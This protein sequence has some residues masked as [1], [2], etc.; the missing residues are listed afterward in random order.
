MNC[1][2]AACQIFIE[3]KELRNCMSDISAIA[4]SNQ[5]ISY[6]RTTEAH[7]KNASAPATGFESATP[8]HRPCRSLIIRL[9]ASLS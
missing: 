8:T 9:A 3:S 2:T 4:A 7:R 5:K 1:A 6:E